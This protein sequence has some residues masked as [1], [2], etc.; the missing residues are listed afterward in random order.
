MGPMEVLPLSTYDQLHPL[1]DA[2]GNW[3]GVLSPEQLA[4][5][6]TTESVCTNGMAGTV[7]VHNARC[8]H[9]SKPNASPRPR[10]LLLNTFTAVRNCNCCAL[11]TTL[12][13]RRCHPETRHP[14]L[15]LSTGPRA[16]A[17]G[18]H[19][20]DAQRERSQFHA[21]ARPALPGGAV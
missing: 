14:H 19:E 21:G 8:V 17:G 1:E 4:N 7:T 10:P 2:E 12:C 5:I 20:H 13:R 11:P 18:G 15:L 6:P 3:T 9:G 16:A